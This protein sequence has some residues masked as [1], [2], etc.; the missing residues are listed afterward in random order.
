MTL[1]YARIKEPPI[2][3]IISKLDPVPDPYTDTDLKVRIDVPTYT[4][5]PEVSIHK[6]NIHKRFTRKIDLETSI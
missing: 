5:P 6:V 1:S 3:N 2:I 4:D